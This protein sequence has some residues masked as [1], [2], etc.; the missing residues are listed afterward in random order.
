MIIEA[1]PIKEGNGK[2]LCRFH[3][4]VQ[5]HL[6]AL[7]A[8]GCEAPRPFITSVLELKLDQNTMFEWHKHSQEHT[9]VPHYN[10]LLDFINL[11]VRA[12]ASES[13]PIAQKKQP[14]SQK[15]ITSFTANATPSP[16]CV[17]CKTEKHPLY[18]CSGFKLLSHDQ[19]I[20]TVRT[21]GLC[22]NC[23]KLAIG[24]FLKECKSIYYRNLTT[25]CFTLKARLF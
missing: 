2:E 8:M 7:K 13:L 21:N 20:G 16:N 1:P 11:H 18:A 19:K 9:D 3:D 25:H 24:H 6:R 10:E 17:I 23:L 5:Q 4:T 15:P 22:M 12:Q 14:H